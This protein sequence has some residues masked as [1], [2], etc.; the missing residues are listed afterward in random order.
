[1][2][3]DSMSKQWYPAVIESLCPET[4]SYKIKTSDGAL[5]RKSQAHLRPYTPQDKMSQAVQC[6]SPPMAQS[7]C[8]QLLK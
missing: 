5:Y 3:Q 7:N 4:R 6:V 2:Y 1:M 8:M